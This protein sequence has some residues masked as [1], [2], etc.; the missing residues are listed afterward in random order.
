MTRWL[1]TGA[2]GMLGTDLIALL[3]TANESVTPL[4][5][6]A[7]DITDGAAAK[8]VVPSA[9]PHVVVNCAAWTAVDDAD[10]HEDEALAVNGHGVANL[11]TACAAVGA[12]LVHVSTDYVFDGT[13]TSPYH[14]DAV[15]DPRTDGGRRPA[16][17]AHLEPRRRQA[18]PLPHPGRRASGHPPRRQF[19]RDD[20]VR[21]GRRS[22]QALRRRPDR[23]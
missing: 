2:N 5:R 19:R 3:T 14:E 7:L 18:D 4:G 20:V 8:E 11:A 10:A 12:A 22:L 1:I 13:A 17:P 16:R 23:T 21:T 9:R 15:P 6:G